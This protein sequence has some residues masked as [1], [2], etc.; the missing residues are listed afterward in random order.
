MK[1]NPRACHSLASL[2]GLP[3]AP[4]AGPGQPRPGAPGL[5]LRA[6][7]DAQGGHRH[8][9]GVAGALRRGPGRVR[10]RRHDP[11]LSPGA[12]RRGPHRDPGAGRRP[13]H[14]SRLRRHV[15]L[16]WCAR[17]RPAPTA[18]WISRP[19]APRSAPR[20]PASCSPTRARSASSTAT[21]RRSPGIVHA[22]G[23]LLYYDGANLNAILGKVRPGDMGFDVIHMNLH[24]TFST[25]HGGGGPGAGPVGVSAAPGALPAGAA[26]RPRRRRLPLAGG[27]ATGPR[28]SAG[29]PP[30]AA[31]WASC[32]APMSMRGCWGARA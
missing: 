13:R 19:C 23:G 24:K 31:T 29:S 21:S 25:P 8:A 2:P 1:Y 32:C 11:R 20:P 27:G 15:R 5:S 26:G 16:S 12:R 6:A 30:S 4:P 10:R 9:R 3:G 18:T 17:S 28:P 14:Q 7:G 22:A